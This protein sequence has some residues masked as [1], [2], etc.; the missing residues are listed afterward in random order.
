MKLR[1][2]RTLHLRYPHELE[3]SRFSP[4]SL[5]RYDV[6]CYLH[7]L[8]RTLRYIASEIFLKLDMFQAHTGLHHR[9][10]TIVVGHLK[11][12]RQPDGNSLPQHCFVK[13][14]KKGWGDAL[15]SDCISHTDPDERMYRAARVERARLRQINSHTEIL[16]WDVGVRPFEQWAGRAL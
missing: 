15:P 2:L 4:K 12:L 3:V 8:A 1:D 6:D 7:D 14:E 16:D 9:L 11:P 5:D 10:D 13:A